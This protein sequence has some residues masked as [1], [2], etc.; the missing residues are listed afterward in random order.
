[1]RGFLVAVLFLSTT[2]DPPPGGENRR[3]ANHSSAWSGLPFTFF[4]YPDRVAAFVFSRVVMPD[5]LDLLRVV[6]SQNTASALGR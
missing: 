3:L 4:D 2:T 6:R 5:D 1:M